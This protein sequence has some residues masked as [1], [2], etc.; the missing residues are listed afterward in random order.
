MNTFPSG[1][2]VNRLLVPFNGVCI[3]SYG[4]NNFH[5][6]ESQKHPW[7]QDQYTLH[8]VLHGSGTLELD[9]RKHKISAQQIFVI[10]P[11]EPMM[12][13]PNPDDK[14]DYVWFCISGEAAEELFRN[15]GASLSTPILKTENGSQ[16]EETLAHLFSGKETPDAYMVNAVFYQILHYIVQPKPKRSKLA[17]L[18]IDQN[19]PS[20]NFTIEKLCKECGLSHAQLCRIF[21]ENYEMSP[22]QYL[23]QKRLNYAQRLLRETDL[24][25]EAVARSCGYSDAANFMKSFKSKVGMSAGAY[26]TSTNHHFR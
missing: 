18:L 21:A 5:Y 25:I 19:F 6:I 9:G 16:I 7:I 14:W 2:G 3:T 20:V 15:M 13:Y 1:R 17:K 11:G 22:K 23:M 26:R 4:Y 12:Y 10:P 8:F 24:K